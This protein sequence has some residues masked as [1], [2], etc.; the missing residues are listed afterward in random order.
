MGRVAGVY[1]PGYD[2]LKVIRVEADS[3]GEAQSL[4][5]DE[6]SKTGWRI[7]KSMQIPIGNFHFLCGKG[8]ETKQSTAHWSW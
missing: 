5:E 6:A 1:D 4:A 2:W 8:H 7:M 3:E